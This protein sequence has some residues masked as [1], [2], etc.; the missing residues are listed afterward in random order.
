MTNLARRTAA[1]IALVL[2][3]GGSLLVAAPAHAAE[4]PTVTIVSSA[5]PSV[6]GQPVTVT[7]TVV[8]MASQP[9]T[10][11][12]VAFRADGFTFGTVPVSAGGTATSP[13]AVGEDGLPLE[14]TSG[15]SDFVGLT[16]TYLPAPG[17]DVWGE[18]T[19][20]L[21]AQM[22]DRSASTLDLRL[23]PGALVA[24][25]GGTPPGGV[26]AGSVRPTGTVAFSVA[27]LPVGTAPLNAAGRASLPRSLPAGQV[28]HV[29]ASY[30]GDDRY[31]GSTDS[32][33]RQDPTIT[34]TVWS[35][36]AQ[37]RAGWYRAPVDVLFSCRPHGARL[38][39]A[40]PKEVRVKKPGVGLSVTG[41]ILAEDGGAATVVVPG[42]NLD[43]AKPVV[44]IVKGRCKATDKLSGVA[45]CKLRRIGAELVA[46]AVDNAGNRAVLRVPAG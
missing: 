45:R 9:V 43:R 13:P 33:T 35:R 22:V 7:A 40:C 31:T 21:V 17:D 23:E 16:A 30:T 18:A 46:V 14:I 8:G 37:T 10:T 38:V 41:T 28:Q 2:A 36:Y 24:T 25:L 6:Y 32:V 29:V 26:Q 19:S 3:P 1:W 12:S 4:A 44:R 42:I 20:E 5:N 39:G 15:I 11:G 34:A 27:G